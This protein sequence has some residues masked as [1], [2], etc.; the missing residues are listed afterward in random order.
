MMSSEA[1][2]IKQDTSGN[3]EP[4]ILVSGG[5]TGWFSRIPHAEALAASRRVIRLQLI[6]VAPGLS[7]AP[8]PPNYSTD[9]EVTDLD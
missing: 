1:H 4:L 6:S 8:P 9:F 7:G 2:L 5:L 3:G